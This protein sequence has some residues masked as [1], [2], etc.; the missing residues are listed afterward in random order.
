MGQKHS[1]WIALN[2]QKNVLFRG[3]VGQPNINAKEFSQIEV[4]L[5]PLSAQVKTATILERAHKLN[6]KREQANQMTSKILQA[7]FLQMFG[8]PVS[9]PMG[10]NELD[11]EEL[12]KVTSGDYFKLSEHSSH[13]IRLLKINNVSFGR[14]IWDEISY[15]PEKF[16]ETHKDLLLKEGDI[17]MALNRPIIRD[18]LKFGMLTK[19]DVPAIL[20]QRVGRFDILAER[21]F[22]RNFLFGFLSTHAFFNIVLR[23]L[24]GSDQ[25][26]INPT[27]LAKVKVIV[28][29][30]QL[31]RKFAHS[32]LN[33][34]AVSE[35]QTQSTRQ[36]T[37]LFNSLMSKAFK[38]ELVLDVPETTGPQQT[39]AK[40]PTL[41]DYMKT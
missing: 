15:L 34:N 19:N 5:L 35:K 16:M 11:F 4:P 12:I 41:T 3:E 14:I 28:P 23:K 31:Q 25:P 13:G 38:G 18:Q 36:I 2:Y 30:I 27:Q 20:Y 29:P 9:N 37:Q 6:Q 17:L 10:W 21:R 40:P 1:A 39:S 7:V 8:D 32:M 24:T 33:I 22:D 26:Y